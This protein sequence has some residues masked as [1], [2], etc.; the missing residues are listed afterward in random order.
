M[1]PESEETPQKTLSCWPLAFSAGLLGIGQ[2]GLLVILPVL[3]IQTNLS[4]SVWAALL[5]LGSMLFLPSSPWWGKQISLTG[6]KTVVLWALG[7]YGVSFT[8]L[9][10]GS[11][12]MAIGAVTT[13]VGLGIL[14][15]ARIAYG[16]TVSAMVPACQV[17][18]LQ[19]AGEGN[20]MAAL[21]TISSG[22]S[23]GRL[24]GPLC[25]AAMLVIHPIAP[26]CM[27]MAAP[28]LA[29][30]MLLRLPGTP[31][32]PTPKRKSVSLKRDY[33]PYLL[34]AMLLAA[35]MS[36]MQLGLSP[37]L[38][39]Q[40]ATDTTTI[41]Q[42]VAWLLG[43]SAVAA[44]IAQ[45]VVLRPQRL[46]PVNLLLSAGMLMS[47]GLA[48]MLAE[49]LWLFY[50]GCAVLS[51]GAALATPAYQL[52]LN[53]KLADG[54]GAGWLAASHTLGYGLCALLVP[55]VSKTGVSI[56]LIVTAL[57]A[58]VLFTIVSACIWHYR[59]IK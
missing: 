30:V 31:P 51:F 5:M 14:I 19:R 34:C 24:F 26:V 2:N 57:F 21:A 16:L 44:L 22:L 27:L 42:Q 18:A 39:R 41:S 33:L 25:A 59:T 9:G 46:T 37:A 36:M 49:Q 1:P 29:L 56:A 47:S 28:A 20:R 38:T 40:F 35:A 15:I 7:G 54:T 32:Q 8:L 13:A 58:A 11:L 52:L 43:L 4:L 17:W 23:C 45:F 6:S 55:L 12:L 10:L 3:V 53:D 48:I 50:L